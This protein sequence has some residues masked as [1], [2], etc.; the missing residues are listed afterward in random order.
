VTPPPGAA[1][2]I[3]NE[4]L[5]RKA[6]ESAFRNVCCD[7]SGG[8]TNSALVGVSRAGERVRSG[9]MVDSSY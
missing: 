7:R 6:V 8:P 9:E 2:I 1:G 3:V 4:G 5:F